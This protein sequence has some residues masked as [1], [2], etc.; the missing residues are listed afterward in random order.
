MEFSEKATGLIAKF[1]GFSSKPYPDP[2]TKG[3]PYTIGYGTTIYPNGIKVT[4]K[5][6]AISIVEAIGFLKNYLDKNV[7]PVLQKNLKVTL[8][9]NQ[10]DALASLIYNIGPTNFVNS[11]LLKKINSNASIQ[12]IQT[13]WLSWNKANKKVMQGLT[14]R[15]EAE[16]KLYNTK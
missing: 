2:A 8:N 16:F 3:E 9:Q 7:A 14:N 4:M 1:E 11:T 6:K 10:I 13:Q 5:D 15:R 12:E